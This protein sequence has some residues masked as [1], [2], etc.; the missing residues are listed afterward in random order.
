M[1]YG[2]KSLGFFGRTTPGVDAAPIPTINL[3]HH[4]LQ[5]LAGTAHGVCEGDE[6]AMVP[7]SSARNDFRPEGDLVVAKVTH[8]GALKSHLEFSNMT[9]AYNESG[10]TALALTHLCLRMFPIRLELRQPYPEEWVQALYDR[11]SLDVYD[12]DHVKPGFVFSFYVAVVGDNLYEIRDEFNQRIPNLPVLA[13]DPDEIASH[14]LDILEHL[15]MFQ[16]VTKLT[17]KSSASS[18]HPFKESFDVK[19]INSAGREFDPGC[20]EKCDHPSCLIEAEPGEELELV[21]KNKGNNGGDSLYLHILNI[22][23]NWEIENILG[24]NHEVIPPRQSN[25]HLDFPQGTSG[26]W[27]KTLE[28]QIPS[29][30]YENGHAHCEDIIKVFLTVQLTSFTSLE[31]PNIRKHFESDRFS[32]IRRDHGGSLS[33]D[34][35]ALNFRIR[36]LVKK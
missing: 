4:G 15:A 13:H 22:G 3:P 1:F 16:M 19:L 30:I 20:S 35:A 8:V 5:L 31:L 10:L 33:D 14:I 25:R 36:S 28:M 17:N 27:R 34:W 26:E 11:P 9:S 23:P 12:V 29:E 18:V 7:L 32:R 6:F 24:G 21:V 2:N